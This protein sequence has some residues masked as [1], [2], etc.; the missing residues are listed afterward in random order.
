MADVIHMGEFCVGGCMFNTY[1]TCKL[2]V[3]VAG[4]IH[5]GGFCGG[6]CILDDKLTVISHAEGNVGG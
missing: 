3:Y 6:D 1:M 4:E 5:R 2:E